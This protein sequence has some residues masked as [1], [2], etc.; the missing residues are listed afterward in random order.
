MATSTT[1]PSLAISLLPEYRGLGIGTQ[2]LRALLLLLRENG[3]R[4]VSLSVQKENSAL[5]LY[6]RM[7]F[8]TVA[9]KGTEYLMLWDGAPG[10]QQE[11]QTDGT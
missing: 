3:Y 2:L 1:T 11:N 4:R 6:Q 10:G 8:H 9:E 7:G 5:R